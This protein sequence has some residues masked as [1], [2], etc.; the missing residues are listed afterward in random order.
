MKQRKLI[1]VIFIEV[2]VLFLVI[3]VGFIRPPVDI[4]IHGTY[5]ASPFEIADFQLRDQRGKIFSKTNLEGHWS[6][7]FFGFTHCSVLCP[8]TMAELNTMYH[9]LQRTLPKNELPQVIFVS[10]DPERDTQE[11]LS[12]FV[13][14]F[15]PHFIA[16]RA[17]M[18]ETV[19]LEKQFHVSAEKN[20][21][22]LNHSLEIV[23]LNPEAKV[24]AYLSY[25]HQAEQLAGDYQKVLRERFSKK[26]FHRNP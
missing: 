2:L 5:I 8:T 19:L 9:T 24:Q 26:V 4:K 12:Q 25:P 15:N 6:L 16:I 20:D 3:Y 14:T 10:I 23:L 22:S 1:A 7:V 11:R 21:N 17:N 18:A 13:N